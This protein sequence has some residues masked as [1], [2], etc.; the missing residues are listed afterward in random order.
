MAAAEQTASLNLSTDVE[1]VANKIQARY[2]YDDA[3]TGTQFE[4][5]VFR[6]EFLVQV[7]SATAAAMPATLLFKKP[8]SVPPP[9]DANAIY[10]IILSAAAVDPGRARISTVG[11]ALAYVVLKVNQEYIQV[12]RRASRRHY[13]LQCK[14]K[15]RQAAPAYALP[16]LP[17]APEPRAD[18]VPLS[19]S[20][21]ASIMKRQRLENLAQFVSRNG[22]LDSY[23]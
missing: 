3:K 4:S 16:R 21:Q 7:V 23:T 14:G 13:S 15:P 19:K 6:R 10:P 8:N 5:M 1:V 9:V 11:Q 18:L 12:L 17:F 2:L 20:S 22:A